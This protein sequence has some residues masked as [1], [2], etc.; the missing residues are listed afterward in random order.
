V[1]KTNTQKMTVSG[2]SEEVKNKVNG[3][4]GFN[5]DTLRMKLMERRVKQKRENDPV[6]NN[7]ILL[8]GVIDNEVEKSKHDLLVS[9]VDIGKEVTGFMEY[10]HSD[11]TK[12]NYMSCLRKFFGWTDMEKIDPPKNYKKGSGELSKLL[13]TYS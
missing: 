9:K 12:T 1:K 8:K 13:D 11:K 3:L 2:H 7:S 6:F 10:Q 5:M 4:G